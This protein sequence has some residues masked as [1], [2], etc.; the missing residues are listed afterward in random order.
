M[1]SHADLDPA[2]STT[3]YSL[4]YNLANGTTVALQQRSA[5]HSLRMKLMQTVPRSLP[6]INR[7][8]A[9]AAKGSNAFSINGIDTL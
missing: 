7:I 1:F 2:A 9:T 8:R 3:F 6:R 5:R 4:R